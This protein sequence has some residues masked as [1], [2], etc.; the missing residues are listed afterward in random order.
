MGGKLCKLRGKAGASPPQ[1][2]PHPGTDRDTILDLAQ[3]QLEA[4][5]NNC[6]WDKAAVELW[7]CLSSRNYACLITPLL[8]NLFFKRLF[9]QKREEM[10]FLY[11]CRKFNSIYVGYGFYLIG[12]PEDN[13]L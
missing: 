6:G 11:Q 5:P 9:K 10:I 2:R 13:L 7:A 4:E 12:S 3:T 8:K 1:P